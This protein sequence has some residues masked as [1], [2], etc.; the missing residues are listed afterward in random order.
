MRTISGWAWTMRHPPGDDRL[1]RSVAWDAD[2]HAL[3]VTTDGVQF[4]N[5]TSWVPANTPIDPAVGLSSVS[6]I[7]PGTWLLSGQNGLLAVL[8][9]DGQVRTTHGPADA[10]LSVVSGDPAALAVAVAVVEGRPPLL[11]TIAAGHFF[12]PLP[13][14]AARTIAA[15]ARLDET[16]WLI[17]GR[18]VQG[19]G[20]SAVYG[21]LTFDVTFLLAPPTDA[22][23]SAAAHVDRGFG[24]ALGRRGAAV[25]FDGG[26]AESSIVEGA[27]DIASA[28]MDVQGRAWAG[29]T[30]R[31]FS[32]GPE[33]RTPWLTAWQN[34][35]WK[36]PFVSIHADVGVVT[37]MTVDGAVVQGRTATPGRG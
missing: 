25:R 28:A 3:T 15:V 23:T 29:T 21:A 17:A 12:R 20:F 31:L 37:A 24:V 33:P 5:G 2:G 7:R 6:L 26:H 14:E 18:T 19:T 32:Q 22:F 16:H 30:G 11:Y 35:A 36:T 1:V 9:T 34:P 8:G 13:L 10:E 4:W 27:P